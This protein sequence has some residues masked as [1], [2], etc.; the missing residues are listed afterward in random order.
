MGN[1]RNNCLKLI[2]DWI[3][4]KQSPVAFSQPAVHDLFQSNDV[5]VYYLVKSLL[6]HAK[7]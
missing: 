4:A 5:T 2:Y 1:A 6:G 7:V 3:V